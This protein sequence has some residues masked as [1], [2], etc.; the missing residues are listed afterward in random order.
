MNP[1]QT[2]IQKMSCPA[3]H[4]WYG[5]AKS[6]PEAFSSRHATEY[7][8]KPELRKNLNKHLKELIMDKLEFSVCS[9]E[10]EPVPKTRSK[11]VQKAAKKDKGL[12]S[13]DQIVEHQKVCKN[14]TQLKF[15]CPYKCD[16][17][18]KKPESFT[19]D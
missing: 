17:K 11:R 1:T 14:T 6:E 12:W 15:I 3:Y 16:K 4:T 8:R 19:I 10:D 13:Y 2:E 7:A 5:V 9:C 18:K